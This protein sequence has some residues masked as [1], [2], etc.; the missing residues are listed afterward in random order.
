MYHIKADKH[1]QPSD[2]K[3]AEPPTPTRVAQLQEHES[4]YPSL[5]A[6]DVLRDQLLV[7]GIHISTT[8]HTESVL[9]RA[10]TLE[11]SVRVILEMIPA[12]RLFMMR[13]ITALSW[14]S[15][16]AAL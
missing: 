13:V 7:L 3:P 4:A 12:T 5:G 10:P 16:T 11:H 2:S 9:T 1:K 6:I 14:S 15:E 8:H